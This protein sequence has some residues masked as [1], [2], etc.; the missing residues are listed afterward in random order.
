MIALYIHIEAGQK[1]KCFF[2][3][4][5]L[6]ESAE[7]SYTEIQKGFACIEIKGRSLTSHYVFSKTVE[8]CCTSSHCG[9]LVDEMFHAYG[10]KLRIAEDLMHSSED[11]YTAQRTT[12]L[13][14]NL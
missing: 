1:R 8:C 7:S 3:L 14:R 4:L 9:L 10:S 13:G 5:L 6:Y 2:L 11:N 12:E